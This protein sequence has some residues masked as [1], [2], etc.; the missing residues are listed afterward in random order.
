MY[1][2]Y[3]EA[4]IY[5]CKK[6]TQEQKKIDIFPVCSKVK[7][8]V[9]IQPRIQMEVKKVLKIRRGGILFYREY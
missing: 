3:V 9:C 6:R 4:D 8:S 7:V 1:M 5:A 2:K